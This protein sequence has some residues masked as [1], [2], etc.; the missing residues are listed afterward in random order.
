MVKKFALKMPVNAQCQIDV[1]QAAELTV[2][3]SAHHTNSIKASLGS[4][5]RI[6]YVYFQSDEIES[7]LLFQMDITSGDKFLFFTEPHNWSALN[8]HFG[9]LQSGKLATFP[10][11]RAPGAGAHWNGKCLQ[12]D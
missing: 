9:G 5:R 11:M 4:I 12:C 7:Q 1:N 10:C 6:K 3:C 8:S 2:Y